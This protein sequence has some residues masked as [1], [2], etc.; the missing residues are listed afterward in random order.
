MV[1]LFATA[2]YA[3]V[4]ALM[5]GNDKIDRGSAPDYALTAASLTPSTDFNAN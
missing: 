5:P 2:S 1:A 3:R 4:S